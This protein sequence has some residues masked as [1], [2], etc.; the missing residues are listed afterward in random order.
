MEPTYV[1][2]QYVIPQVS[3]HYVPQCDD[4]EGMFIF[5]TSMGSFRIN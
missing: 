4:Y 5:N 3:T 1:N 2:A